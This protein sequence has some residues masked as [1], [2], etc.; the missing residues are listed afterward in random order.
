MKKLLKSLAVLLLLLVAALALVVF[1]VDPNDYKDEIQDRFAAA[2]GHELVISGQLRLALRPRPVLEVTQA[3]LPG[4]FGEQGPTLADIGRLR[5]YPRLGPLLTGRFELALVRVEDLD[6]HLVRDEQGRENWAVDK[7]PSVSMGRVRATGP[8]ASAPASWSPVLST[9]WAAEAPPVTT[10]PVVDQIEVLDAQVIWDDRRSGRRLAFDGLEILAG[11]IGLDRPVTW[12]VTGA[13]RA[14]GGSR[15]AALRAEGDLL[16]VGADPWPM[17]LEPLRV[18]LEGFDLGPDL[19]VDLLLRTGVNANLDAGRYLADQAVVEIRASGAALSAGEIEAKVGARLD[20][21]LTAERLRITSLSI[22]SGTLSANGE[23]V[24]Q[25]LL[26][27][28]TFSGDLKLDE[29]D[30]RAWLTQ[31]GLTLPWTADAE[32]F[33]RLALD[34]DWRLKEGRFAVP[35]LVLGLDETKVTGKVEQ[36]STSPQG[37]R[38]DL[39]ADRL[40]LDRY[41]PPSEQGS[42][43]PETSPRPV[44][45]TKVST[46]LTPTG[47]GKGTVP[48]SAVPD[49]APPTPAAPAPAPAQPPVTAG[50]IGGLNLEGRL[51]IDELVLSRLRFGDTDLGIRVEDGN[52]SI[53]DQI[54]RFYAGR[55]A[56]KLGLDLRGAELKVTVTQHGEE[57]QPGLLLADLSWG[58]RLSGHGEFTADLVATGRD[59]DA[60]RRSLAGTLSVHMPQGAIKDVNLERMV[61]EA[62]ARLQGKAPPQDLPRHTDFRDLRAGAKIRNGVLDNR[63]LTATA[64]HLRITGAGALD[65]VR[66]QI[67]YR[68]QPMFVEPPRGCGIKELEGIPI[69]VHLTGPLVQPRWNLDLGSVLSEVAKRRFGKQGEDLLQSLEERTGIEKLEE[70]LKD[71]DLKDLDLKGLKGLFGR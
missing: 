58:D 23:V 52:L 38:F 36:V 56:G 48:V 63:D 71:L 41:L 42:A 25:G 51:R 27:A 1:V 37:Y 16:Q 9:A 14:D 6:L 60:L 69:P 40:D 32:T 64:D 67:D 65:L 17:R 29:L 33:R 12:R 43:R 7:A 35:D 2:T 49:K 24:G 53:D 70:G 45:V 22:R 47:P 44:P 31:Q 21:D 59:M 54:G 11:P 8:R 57:I 18:R 50:P 28:P 13:V 19:A 34:A 5:L 10:G 15:P 68:F 62:Q 30:L 26:S 4:A 61:R 66:E 3:S 39:V 46:T 55:L 20:L